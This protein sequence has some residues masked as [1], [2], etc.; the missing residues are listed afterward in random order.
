MDFETKIIRAESF[1][2]A[3]FELSSQGYKPNLIIAHPGWGESMFLKEV[4]PE[5]ALLLYC[6]FFY[7]SHGFDVNFD[8]EFPNDDP[9]D[10]CRLI[11]K[12]INN[13]I[14]LDFAD[15]GLSPTVWQASSY[16]ID[17]QKK[18][19]I[20]HDGIDTSAL[21]PNP[22]VEINLNSGIKLTNKDEIITFVN[23]NLEPYRGYH[24]FM[25]SL[26][27]LLQNRPNLKVL[28]IGG[29][30]T[31]Y[32]QHPKNGRSW[33]EIFANEI[34]PMINDEDLKRII[35]LG[36]VPYRQY[37]SIIQISSVH[38][39]LTYPFVLS[40]SLLEAMSLGC[41]VIASKTKP[42][43]ELIVNNFNGILVDFFDYETLSIEIS[44]LLDNRKLRST[45]SINARKSIVKNYDLQTV[46]LPKQL[47]LIDQLLSKG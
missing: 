4:W 37:I 21:K 35:F 20:I 32:G 41:P 7:R 13:S 24:I 39:Y 17:F 2:R 1:F 43:E 36:T 42:L 45:I 38:I 23:R 10:N 16:P 11:L 46:C 8:P 18:I 25:R 47:N 12:N 29:D 30:S 15:A 5:S 34:R 31:S 19:K 26:P 27:K 14:H 3:A 6:E 28:I 22:S 33:K 44:N 40:W 9:A